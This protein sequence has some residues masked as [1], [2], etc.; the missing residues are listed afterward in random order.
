M[1]IA[2]EAIRLSGWQQFI[3]PLSQLYSDASAVAARV[4][5]Q[6]RDSRS[7]LDAAAAMSIFFQEVDPT[8][9]SGA[10]NAL[11]GDLP[12]DIPLR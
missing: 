10:L 3:N 6:Q 8:R 2:V 7:R 9:L 4:E 11:K 12:T 1:I 5:Q